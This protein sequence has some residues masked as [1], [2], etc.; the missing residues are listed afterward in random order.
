[1]R[2]FVL[3]II[4]PSQMAPIHQSLLECPLVVMLL[5]LFFTPG[6]RSD[7]PPPISH[8]SDL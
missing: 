6:L 1:M 3:V 5:R 7:R 2:R 4:L 8:H